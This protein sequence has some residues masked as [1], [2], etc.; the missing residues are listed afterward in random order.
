MVF[1]PWGPLLM[2][3]FISFQLVETNSCLGSRNQ[4][5]HLEAKTLPT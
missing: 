2:F 5:R 1:V 4:E 3:G